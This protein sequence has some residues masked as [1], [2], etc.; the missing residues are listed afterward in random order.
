MRVGAL[1][2]E[3]VAASAVLGALIAMAASIAGHASVGFGT[4]L[5][6]LLGSG[7]G[8]LIV[9]LF[10]RGSSFVMA[11]LIRLSVFSALALVAALVLGSSAWSVLIGVGVAQL[12]MVAAG[13]RQGLRT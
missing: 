7:N 2:R 1:L 12:V 6:L 8:Y 4:A 5:G 3:T 13:V 11:S 9:A 10:D